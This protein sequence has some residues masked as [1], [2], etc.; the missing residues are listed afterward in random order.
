MYLRKVYLCCAFFLTFIG[1]VGYSYADLTVNIL[2]VNGTDEKKEKKIHHLLPKE[3]T[4]E[5][6]LDT[7]GLEVDYDINEE[8]HV[9][10]GTITLE[11]KET[12][13]FKVRVRDVWTIDEQEIKDIKDQID[14]GLTRI[15]GSEYYETGVTKK[16]TLLKRLNYIVSQQEEF[17]D[18]AQ[19]RIDRYRIYDRELKEIRSNALSVSYWKSKPPSPDDGNV[20]KFVIEVEN[21]SEDE[22]KVVKQKHYLPAEVK[23]EHFVDTLGFDISYDALEKQSF[24][25]K[26]EELRP[27]EKKR[28]DFSIIDIWKLDM[29]EVENLKDRARKAYKL[30]EKSEYGKSAEYLIGSIKANIERIE[31][32]QGQ[33][34]NIKDH[35]STFRVNTKRYES[36]KKDVDALEDLLK[37]LRENLERSMLK[38]V[39][40]KIKSLESI[41]DIAEAAFGTKPSMNNAWKII[42][43]IMICVGVFTAFHFTVWGKRSKASK[44][45]DVQKKEE[46]KKEE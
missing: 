14:E 22:L 16:E 23:P 9:L 28:Y 24:L 42:M 15:E 11:A 36:A 27:G 35:I 3:L 7:A 17:S 39:L 37:A 31:A 25:T 29:Q 12:R 2:A 34:E 38:N 43:W 40:Q 18:N 6:I 1:L 8:A 5:D 4:A 20:V 33:D 26:E 30:L 44:I 32:S 13:T 19:K 46:E 21:P 45:T 10:K 41:A